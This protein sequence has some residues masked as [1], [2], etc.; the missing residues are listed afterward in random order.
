M[1][2][3]DNTNS[4]A[5]FK[6]DRKKT[7][8]H[9]DRQG[10]ADIMCPECGAVTPFWVSGWLKKAKRTGQQFL[11]LAFTPKDSPALQNDQQDDNFDDGDIP[12]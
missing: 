12:F 10:Q 9:P 4:G 7:E 11:S 6:N 8:R 2:E 5:M 3:Y 1:S